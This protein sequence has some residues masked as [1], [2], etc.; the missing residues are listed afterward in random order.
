MNTDKFKFRRSLRHIFINY[1]FDLLVALV[2][3]IMAVQ[4]SA[5]LCI[6]LQYA[7]KILEMVR[8]LFQFKYSINEK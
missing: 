8:A 5:A 3:K 6:K 7:K 4:L 1:N 2:L